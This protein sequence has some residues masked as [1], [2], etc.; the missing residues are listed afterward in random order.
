MACHPDSLLFPLP[1]GSL[2]VFADYYRENRE[3]FESTGLCFVTTDEPVGAEYPRDVPL[4]ALPLGGVL[5][6]RLDSVSDVIKS[7]YGRHVNVKQGYARCSV[8]ALGERAA[9]T[10]DRGLA[11]A[12]LSEGVDVLLL[13]PGGILLRAAVPA[14][15]NETP[16]GGTVRSDGFIGGSGVLLDV[17][18]GSL[19]HCG[20]VETSGFAKACAP[21]GTHDSSESRI[22]CDTQAVPGKF[23]LDKPCIRTNSVVPVEKSGQTRD[24]DGTSS[25][26]P[27]REKICGFFRRHNRL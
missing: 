7:A 5:Y 17:G 23:G 26:A 15:A 13:P 11:Y 2:L 10:A 6:G 19:E 4:N 16:G 14:G 1:D 27:A 25:S 21:D 18:G 20:L 24:I 8:L 9:V 3:L 12:L 22:F